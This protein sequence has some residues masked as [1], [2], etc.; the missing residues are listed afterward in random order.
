MKQ[1]KGREC[2]YAVKCP[3]PANLRNLGCHS[4]KVV[5]DGQTHDDF[6]YTDFQIYKFIH[7]WK[8][9]KLYTHIYGFAYFNK[10]VNR[11]ILHNVT[12]L[13]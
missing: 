11:S 13:L 1:V 6:Q 10:L 8:S 2:V 7:R 4:Q 3:C 12:E 5:T 9:Y